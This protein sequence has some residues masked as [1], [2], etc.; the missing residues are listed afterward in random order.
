MAE[1]DY[2][3]LGHITVDVRAAD[4]RRT[5]GGSA[6]Y[7][8]LQAARLGMR[9]Q[10][11][12][13][14]H[15]SEL[16]PLLA[17]YRD[18]F[19]IV[20]QPRPHTTTFVTSGIG[21]IRRQQRLMWAGELADPGELDAAIVHVA[22]VARETGPLRA[23]DT[24]FVGVTPQGLVRE[25]SAG[26]DPFY[27]ALDSRQLPERCDAIV[28]DVIEHE[29]AAATVSTLVRAGVLVAVTAADDG[30]ELLLGERSV[31]LPALP[32][33][34]VEDLGAGDVFAA[35]FFCALR[36]GAGPIDAANFGQSAACL[37]LAGAGPAAVATRAA[38]EAHSANFG[39]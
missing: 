24:S 37:R 21:E 15:R 9:T 33:D 36:E 4:G 13:A 23:A 12:T 2:I 5:P 7:S 38:I 27:V 16:G 6:L 17:P 8:G 11:I 39:D 20:I 3:V 18:E 26:G 28:L 25:W 29:F 14:G 10:I 34:V 31:A 35:A 32:V 1:Y 19:D 30:V 22:P